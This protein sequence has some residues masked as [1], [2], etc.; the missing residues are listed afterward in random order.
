MHWRAGP[1]AST[2]PTRKRHGQSIFKETKYIL[3]RRG[4]YIIKPMSIIGTPNCNR[5]QYCPHKKWRPL[6]P[7]LKRNH[8][9]PYWRWNHLLMPSFWNR[10]RRNRHPQRGG[11]KEKMKCEKNESHLLQWTE[12]RVVEKYLQM[13]RWSILGSSLGLGIQKNP[14][15]NARLVVSHKIQYSTV[16]I[17]FANRKIIFYKRSFLFSCLFSHF[18]S[19]VNQK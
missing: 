5:H 6:T 14:L 17:F 19:K 18:R 1:R 11:N 3:Q 7:A 9:V 4:K 13:G 16:I 12:K 15:W 8:K 10:S 2:L